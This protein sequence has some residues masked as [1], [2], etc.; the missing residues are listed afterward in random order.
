[1]LRRV[2]I[3]ACASVALLA[4]TAW[5]QSPALDDPSQNTDPGTSDEAIQHGPQQLR[6]KLA[7]DG[8][9]DVKIAPGSYIVSAKDKDGHTVIMMISPTSMTMMKVP[10]QN[11]SQ[12]Q[13][14]GTKQDELIQQ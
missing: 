10:D 6:E 14:P 7:E 12:A 4:G 1:M 9:T 13:V 5:A 3:P 2:I 8:Y 11:P